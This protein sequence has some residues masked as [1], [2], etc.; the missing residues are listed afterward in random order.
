MSQRAVPSVLWREGMFL[1]TQHFQ[2]LAREAAGLAAGAS[3]IGRAQGHGLVSLTLDLGRLAESVFDV[4]ALELVFPDGT[5]AVVPGNAE[6][7][8]TGF[9]DVFKEPELKVWLAIPE[10]R[11][12]QPAIDDGR[13]GRVARF[14]V[15]AVATHDENL[16]DSVQQLEFRML[17]IKVF[18]GDAPPAGFEAIEVARLVREGRPVALPA[19][20]PNFVPPV[21]ECGGAPTLLRRIT[22]LAQEARRRV[23]DL[24]ERVPTLARLSDVGRGVDFASLLLLQS[25]NRTCATLEQLARA[26]RLAPEHAYRELARCCGDLALFHPAR[27]VPALLAFD[28]ARTDA[29]F[30][31]VLGELAALM[32]A[33]VEHPY[34]CVP[35][36]R[37]ALVPFFHQVALP[38]EWLERRA[39]VWLGV[40]L[41]RRP[42]EAA[43]LVPDGIKLLAPSEKQRVIDGMIPGISL[44]HERVPPLA[45]PK[46]EDLHYFRISTEGES[47]NSWLSIERERSALIVNPLDD[48]VDARFEFYVEKPRRHG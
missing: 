5:L 4:R 13:D 18:F 22:E 37:D 24:A 12:N 48:L 8:A 3:S 32:G 30:K 27:A 29:C 6:I 10:A 7:S 19:L 15:Q 28:P 25:L 43:R 21:L 9:A 41:A 47:R 44:V 23:R 35:F 11:E 34:E 33:E 38:A 26:P 31:N 40:Q 39:E 14:R 45:F 36:D 46:R 1:S 16:R 17:R 20:D 2:A 42:E